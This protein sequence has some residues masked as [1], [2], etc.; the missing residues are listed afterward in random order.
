M[1]ESES[2]PQKDRFIE[3]LQPGKEKSGTPRKSA[4][5]GEKAERSKEH[6]SEGK[7]TA[8]TAP[9][10]TRLEED[11]SVTIKTLRGSRDMKT[12]ENSQITAPNAPSLR[13][14]EMVETS[15]DQSAWGILSDTQ[16]AMG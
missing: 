15:H 10:G 14:K 6:H 3:N 13:V 4:I 12:P 8:A 2:H 5:C 7:N 16:K 9:K 11:G 1:G